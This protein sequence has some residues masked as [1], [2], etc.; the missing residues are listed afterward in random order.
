MCARVCVYVCV[1]VQAITFKPLEVETSFL[2]NR[3]NICTIS[4][5]STFKLF[6]RLRSSENRG[7]LKARLYQSKMMKNILCIL[8]AFCDLCIYAE[9][10]AQNVRYLVQGHKL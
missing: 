2:I 5:S 6:N 1:C 8:N 7:H 4:R 3:Y 10:S 9:Y